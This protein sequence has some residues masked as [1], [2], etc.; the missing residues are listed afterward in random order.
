MLWRLGERRR[1]G[2]TVGNQPK[3]VGLELFGQEAAR[4]T[5]ERLDLQQGVSTEIFQDQLESPGWN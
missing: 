3:D 2:R 5:G 4:K 1:P